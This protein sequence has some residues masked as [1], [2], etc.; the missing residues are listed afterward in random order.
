VIGFENAEKIVQELYKKDVVVSARGRGLRVS[1][2]VYN[3]E[4]DI[5]KFISELQ[6][7]L[8]SESFRD[9]S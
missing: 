6:K 3:N 2:H 8:D 5:D 1:V 7:L 9:P 4:K